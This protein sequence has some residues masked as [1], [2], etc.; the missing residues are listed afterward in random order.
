MRVCAQPLTFFP[1]VVSCTCLTSPLMTTR[2]LAPGGGA[3]HSP[4]R[5]SACCSRRPAAPKGL[6]STLDIEYFHFSTL[7]L[8]AVIHFSSRNDYFWTCLYTS[9]Y[10][11]ILKR[12]ISICLLRPISVS[13]AAPISTPV[14][15]L[16]EGIQF[17][18]SSICLLGKI[19]YP[20]GLMY[21][22]DIFVPFHP[23][24]LPVIKSALLLFDLILSMFKLT[25]TYAAYPSPW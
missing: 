21:Y 4:I 6:T 12:Q 2:P 8:L 17:Q 24:K 13:C 9:K 11:C 3:N 19:S 23:S 18:L 16:S 14:T 5:S 20:G 10:L 7:D 15:A 1:L 25:S 22:L